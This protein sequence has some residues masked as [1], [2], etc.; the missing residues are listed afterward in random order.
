MRRLLLVLTLTAGFLSSESALADESGDCYRSADPE[1]RIKACSTIIQRDPTD[2][3][4]HQ[5]RARAYELIG[6]LDRTIADYTKIIELAPENA[7]AY[8]SRSRAYARKALADGMKSDELAAKTA[9]QSR[10]AKTPAILPVQEH[11]LHHRRR[12]T[13]WWCCPELRAVLPARW[14]GRR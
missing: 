12:F 14:C 9:A 6:D 8:D 10:A 4:A 7:A 11:R 1:V 3:T 5:N 2:T 13:P